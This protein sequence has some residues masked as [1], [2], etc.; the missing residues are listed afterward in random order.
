MVRRKLVRPYSSPSRWSRRGVPPT[1]RLAS[2]RRSR[3]RYHGPRLTVRAISTRSGWRSGWVRTRSISSRRSVASRARSLPRCAGLYALM[4]FTVSQRTREI[5]I[6][7]ALGARPE[8]ILIAV[9]R[10]ALLQLVASGST[11]VQCCPRELRALCFRASSAGG[12]ERRNGPH[13]KGATPWMS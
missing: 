5:G 8:R 7:I 11:S 2:R 9:L 10:R 1:R 12:A 6:R 4:S 13:R 3:T